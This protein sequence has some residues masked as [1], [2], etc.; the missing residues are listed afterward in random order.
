MGVWLQWLDRFIR[1]RRSWSANFQLVQVQQ[2]RIA[3]RGCFDLKKCC[4][5]QPSP[6]PFYCPYLLHVEHTQLTD[7]L[8][9]LHSKH[10]LG[11]VLR[12]PPHPNPYTGWTSFHCAKSCSGT[13][14][15]IG[16]KS[17]RPAFTPS[18]A[19]LHAVGKCRKSQ[20]DIGLIANTNETARSDEPV[21]ALLCRIPS[22]VM[23]H[24]DN[25]ERNKRS[26]SV[27]FPLV[28]ERKKE[29][30][31]LLVSQPFNINMFWLTPS[32]HV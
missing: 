26:F 12:A 25:T 32:S 14:Q 10:T 17:L 5:V 31:A 21:Q 29:R 18:H 3:V 27:P 15:A 16:S 6:W 13:L 1:E 9:G 2:T 23:L 28:K 4:C 20:T 7:T 30:G 24:P 8:K 22:K 19:S 11:T